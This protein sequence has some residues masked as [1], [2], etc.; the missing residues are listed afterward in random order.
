M[1][2]RR[3]VV[4]Q[5][6]FQTSKDAQGQQRSL[7]AATN[8]VCSTEASSNLPAPGDKP[9][10][11]FL[12]LPG[13]CLAFAM[14]CAGFSA[15][16][17]GDSISI[18]REESFHVAMF[19]VPHFEISLV[20]ATWAVATCLSYCVYCVPCV[21]QLTNTAQG[22]VLGKSVYLVLSS[23]FAFPL[24]LLHRGTPTSIH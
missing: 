15:T 19:P 6:M 14:P 20:A 11:I 18:M 10:R 12:P 7:P 8:F 17:S 13:L 16:S 22:K 1:I 3:S 23:F 9:S 2:C 5:M 4:T 24:H 21:I